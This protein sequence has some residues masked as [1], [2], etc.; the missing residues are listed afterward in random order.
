[1]SH[2]MPDYE[3]SEFEKL[4]T[5]EEQIQYVETH[6]EEFNAGLRA[7]KSIPPGDAEALCES[8]GKYRWEIEN[9]IPWEEV[10]QELLKELFMKD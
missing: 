6:L 4:K 7:D 9:A 8:N 5:R 2:A 3:L 10:E 1:M